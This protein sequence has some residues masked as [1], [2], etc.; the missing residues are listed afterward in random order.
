MTWLTKHS[1]PYDKIY[2]SLSMTPYIINLIQKQSNMICMV[3]NTSKRM[4]LHASQLHIHLNVSNVHIHAKI[5]VSKSSYL[6]Q[7]LIKNCNLFLHVPTTQLLGLCILFSFAINTYIFR[8]YKNLNVLV[9]QYRWLTVLIIATSS[10]A[11][12]DYNADLGQI[13]MVLRKDERLCRW[14]NMLES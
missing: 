6:G 12:C 5:L 2:I 4:S 11:F 8:H 7:L 3:F 10:G 9:E 1:L 13:L 14:F